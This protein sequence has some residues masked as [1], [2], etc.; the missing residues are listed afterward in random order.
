M[1]GDKLFPGHEDVVGGGAPLGA[2]DRGRCDRLLDAR[3]NLGEA[4]PLELAPHTL[5]IGGTALGKNVD[6]SSL[7]LCCLGMAELDA[8]ECLQ[9]V[10]QEPGI[11][12]DGLEDKRFTAG[13]GDT[14][15][16]VDR[17]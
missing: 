12:D 9:M 16:A 5:C 2:P 6:Q 15:T 10:M 7:Y 4:A 14:V 11:I 8:G 1:Q 13:N 3:G 17:A